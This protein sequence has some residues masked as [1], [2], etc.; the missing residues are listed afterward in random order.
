MLAA[1]SSA[2]AD[3]SVTR[4]GCGGAPRAA[5]AATR[6]G[7]RTSR[8]GLSARIVPAPTS[9]ASSRQPSAETAQ[10]R[11]VYGRAGAAQTLLVGNTPSVGPYSVVYCAAWQVTR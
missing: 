10:L 5:R 9:V 11:T 3:V 6:A 8:R 1:G 2:P 4:R 7:E